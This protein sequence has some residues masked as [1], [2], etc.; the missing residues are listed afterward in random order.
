M[1]AQKPEKSVSVIA[2]LVLEVADEELSLGR[3]AEKS[4]LFDFFLHSVKVYLNRR[5]H[6]QATAG[7]LWSPGV[8]SVINLTKGGGQPRLSFRQ[9]QVAAVCSRLSAG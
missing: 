6:R 1:D 2:T 8:R 4:N 5:C 9:S 7:I 3:F